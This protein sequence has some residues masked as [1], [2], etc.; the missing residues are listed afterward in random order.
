[1]NQ[2]AEVTR[3]RR[4]FS[5]ISS[6]LIGGDESLP[7]MSSC[8]TATARI[9]GRETLPA[10]CRERSPTTSDDRMRKITEMRSLFDNWST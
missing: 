4:S 3:G 2:I 8:S 10:I 7:G 5:G 1:M 9:D 6:S